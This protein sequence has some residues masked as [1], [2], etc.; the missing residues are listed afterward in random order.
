MK[1]DFISSK[2]WR[3]D[4]AIGTHTSGCIFMPDVVNF[5]CCYLFFFPLFELQSINTTSYWCFSNYK[6]NLHQASGHIAAHEVAAGQDTD[7][8]DVL[9]RQLL[10]SHPGLVT[11][12]DFEPYEALLVFTFNAP[13][14]SAKR[15]HSVGLIHSHSS[16]AKH[17]HACF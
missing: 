9:S 10:Y 16:E 15:E 14:A 12:G 4:P 17:S 3:Q 7:R 11:H 13:H 1:D 6:S 2:K 5:F 8:S